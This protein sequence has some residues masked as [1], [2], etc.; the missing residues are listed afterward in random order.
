MHKHM[1]LVITQFSD[2]LLLVRVYLQLLTVQRGQQ[3]GTFLNTSLIAS[4]TNKLILL[5][6]LSIN[7]H[8]LIAIKT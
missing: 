7:Q 5:L 8:H 3:Q 1:M 4:N 2:L 6:L